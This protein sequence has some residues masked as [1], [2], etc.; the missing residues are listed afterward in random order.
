MADATPGNPK[1]LRDIPFALPEVGAAEKRRAK[2][3]LTALRER[4]PDAHCELNFSSPHELLVATILSA[5]CTDAA[6]NRATPALFARFPAPADYAK[7]SPEEIEPYVKSLGFF[8]SKARAV[9]ETMRDVAEKHGGEVPR[10][11]DDLLAL[12]GVARK[13]ANVVLGNAFG[14]NVGVVVDTHVQ[15]LSARF[16]LVEEGATVQQIERRLM[17]LFPRESWTDLS[18]LLIFHGRRV[19]KAR[20][21]LC[22]QD[23]I[24]RKFCSNATAPGAPAKKTVK[25]TT[26]KK[27]QAKRPARKAAR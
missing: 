2:A 17:A 21:A 16:G 10:T 9:F 3:I 4:Y 8:R 12:R 23:A 26:K 14:I 7:A 18:H 19:C 11:M 15:R 22:A 20:G 24:C 6:V 1:G 27:T 13:T 25:K 5:Q